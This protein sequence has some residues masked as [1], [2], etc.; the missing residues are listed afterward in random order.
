MVLRTI[1]SFYDTR[2]G[3]QTHTYSS[4][5]VTLLLIWNHGLLLIINRDE[6]I[7]IGLQELVVLQISVFI[8]LIVIIITQEDSII[9]LNVFTFL[10]K[11]LQLCLLGLD[12]LLQGC[13][14]RAKA[15]NDVVLLGALVAK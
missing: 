12:G 6:V 14:P 4:A 11:V 3:I 2:D 1:L 5:L 13:D 15:G 7:C 9:S 10:L 8:L